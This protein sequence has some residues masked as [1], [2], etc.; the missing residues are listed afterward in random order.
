MVRKAELSQAQ[1]LAFE[2]TRRAME[3]KLRRVSGVRLAYPSS[4]GPT[5]ELRIG[6]RTYKGRGFIDTRLWVLKDEGEWVATRLGVTMSPFYVLAGVT[7][8]LKLVRT[9]K[10]FWVRK[11][12]RPGTRGPDVI[13]VTL[14]TVGRDQHVE[15]VVDV[16]TLALEDEGYG[17][18][19]KG[20]AISVDLLESVIQALD[21]FARA[22]GEVDSKYLEPRRLIEVPDR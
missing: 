4:A 2:R 16:R 14:K 5:R 3:S 20:L 19:D 7:Q 8:A 17:F 1:R 10:E 21:R 13:R 6:F 9:G 12:R 18:T 11:G 22:V 15:Q